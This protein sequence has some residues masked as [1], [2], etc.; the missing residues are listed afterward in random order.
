MR[1]RAAVIVDIRRDNQ[2]EHL[3]FKS[4]FALSRNRGEY[5]ALLFGKATPA[6]TTG[7]GAQPIDALLVEVTRARAD[8]GRVRA[9][10]MAE[11]RRSGIPLAAADLETIARFHGAFIAAGPALR[12]TS[13]GRAP[14]AG[15]PDFAQLAT[16]RDRDGRQRSFLASETDFQFVKGLE[17]RNLVIPVVGNF[18]GPHA[19]AAVA[20]WVKANGEKLSA[21][22]ASNV[23]QYLF[24]DGSFEAFAANVDRFPRDAK[25]IVIR[26][27]F[28]FCRGGHPQSVN[29]YYSVQMAQLVDSMMALRKAGHLTSYYD[30]VATG[31]VPP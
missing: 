3:L 9:R 13:F 27:C 28:N 22:Y 18:A 16:E 12:F 6:D 8:A 23:E 31:L 21:L 10:V 2:L 29:G 30:L 20:D 17:D 5:L 24:R 11:V 25:S 4:I 7:A 26:S 1:P 15:Y 14:A 19:L